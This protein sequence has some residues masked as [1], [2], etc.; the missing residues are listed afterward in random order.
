MKV[1]LVSIFLIALLFGTSSAYGARVVASG[2]IESKTIT[3]AISAL[4]FANPISV[5]M[6]LGTIFTLTVTGDTTLNATNGRNGQWIFFQF[7][8]D[9]AGPHT[10][11]FGTNFDSLGTLTTVAS[12]I[13]HTLFMYDGS[14]WHEESRSPVDGVALDLPSL[15]DGAANDVTVTDDGDGT[16]TISTITLGDIVTAGT[17]LSG[18]A[19]DVLPGADADTTI[20]LTAAK[21]IVAG[22]GLT[23]GE[24]NVL[25]G[26]DAD[27]TI[28]VGG[29]DG[30]I[31]NADEIEV[32]GLVASDG[33][34][35]DALTTDADGKATAGYGLAGDIY[36][37]GAFGYD[38]REY[39]AL[40]D[41]STDDSTA[42]TNAIAAAA[43][44]RVI[45]PEAGTS[46]RLSS[47]VTVPAGVTLGI[48]QGGLILIDTG[49]TLAINGTF[50]A[51]GYQIFDLTGTGIATLAAGSCQ[52]IL[53]QWWGA[54]GD[55]STDNA[56]P[57][58]E[59]LAQIPGI[60]RMY[61]PA[62]TYQTTTTIDNF[63]E[64]TYGL[65]S[66]GVVVEG[67]GMSDTIIKYTGT[68]GYAIELGANPSNSW[69][70]PHYATL[71]NMK[72][73][74]ASLTSEGGGVLLAAVSNVTLDHLSFTNIHNTNGIC[75]KS[76][77][78]NNT[79]SETFTD[80]TNNDFTTTGAGATEQY[81][82]KFTADRTAKLKSI[83]VPLGKTGAPAGTIL[84]YIY[85]DD[86]GAPSE[87]NA[88]IDGA[89]DAV[90][91]TAL[92]ADAG[93][94]D[95]TLTWT[96]RA[97]MPDI[98]NTNDYWVVLK[99]VGYTYADA[100]TEV[101]LRVESAGG[102]ADEFAAFDTGGAGWGTSADGVDN[103]V[104]YRSGLNLKN[105][106]SYVHA[107]GA[108]DAAV[109]IDN[110]D[111]GQLV[112]TNSD[113]YTEV[114]LTSDGSG[115]LE[116]KGMIIQANT[117]PA[118]ALQGSGLS[119][120]TN[121]YLEGGGVG[122][123]TTVSGG[124]HFWSQSSL[125]VYMEWTAGTDIEFE[126]CRGPL[127]TTADATVQ[128]PRYNYK[129]YDTNSQWLTNNTGTLTVDVD[130]LNGQ[131]TV[132]DAD[133][134]TAN[135]EFDGDVSKQ[136]TYLPK[137]TYK[138]SAYVKSPTP[139]TDGFWLR[140]RNFPDAVDLALETFTCTT[141][142]EEYS[143]FFKIDDD[144]VRDRFQISIQRL[145][146]QNDDLSVSHWTIE[147]M[148]PDLP[149]Q[150]NLQAYNSEES[151]AAGARVS[152]IEFRGKQSGGEE[153]L[154]ASIIARHV[155]SA[156]DEKGGLAFGVNDGDDGFALTTKLW[157]DSDFDIGLGDLSETIEDTSQVQILMEATKN[158]LIDGSTNPRN[159]TLGVIRFEHTPA[160]PD[161]RAI[162]LD[163]EANGMGDTH[164]IFLA[165][166]A[167][168]IAS[169]E[170]MMG[171]EV[172]LDRSN[173]TGGVM[174]GLRVSVGGAGSAAVH[175]L[176]A[177]PGVEV[178]HQEVGT[179]GAI[180][181]GWDENG[182]FTDV[183]AAFNS[184]VTDVT[185][186]SANGDMVH[187]GDAADFN[188]IEV[189]L[190]T[191]ASGAGVVPT[192]EYSI[193]GPAWT[194]FIPA[195]D[196][197]N[198]FRSSGT[199]AWDESTFTAWVATT[200]NGVNKKYIR[201]TRT[202]VG[203]G[204]SPIEDTI[205]IAVTIEYEWDEDG[206]LSV[207]SI[208][209]PT[210]ATPIEFS[211]DGTLVGDSDTAIP[212]EK[213]VKTYVDGAVPSASFS[214]YDAIVAAAGGDY[215]SVVTACATE[216]AGARIFVKRGT[217]NET[218]NIVMKDGQQLIGQ[219]PEDTIIDFGGNSAILTNDGAGTNRLVQGLTI[220][221]PLGSILVNLD[222]AYDRV[223]N[224]R[225]ISLGSTGT[226]LNVVGPHAVVSR[227]YIEGFTTSNQQGA[228]SGLGHD[229]LMI[230][231]TIENCYRGIRVNGD[232]CSIIGNSLLANTQAAIYVANDYTLISQNVMT[233][234]GDI[235]QSVGRYNVFDG[236]MMDDVGISFTADGDY[237]VVTNN[238]FANGA[239]F[240]NINGEYV[241]I[242]NNLFNGGLG[243][244]QQGDFATMSANIFQGTAFIDLHA[245]AADC[246]ITGNNLVDSSVATN[247]RITDAGDRNIALNNSGVPVVSE[248]QFVEMQNQSGGALAVGDVVT[249]NVAATG[250]EVTTTTTQGDDWVYGICAEAIGNTAWG[251]IQILGKTVALK[252]DGTAD[253][254]VGDLLGT[255]TTAKIAMQAAA[256][257]M[258]FAIA[259][260]AY[261]TDDSSGVIDALLISPR[262]Y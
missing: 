111:A 200:I 222:G 84:A 112:I 148:G 212:T 92:S 248:K 186:F 177:D 259:L 82:F 237:S 40:G 223:D 218:V 114:G 135:I 5:D 55:D 238:L 159:M 221:N 171:L 83:T 226:G 74:A 243:I 28:A 239:E 134:E 166:H 98:V 163:I 242:S 105:F 27:T 255:F 247:L 137:G 36:H 62:G 208:T 215:T 188:A 190:D 133:F 32:S 106:I 169:G 71:K 129:L 250:Y 197:T 10:I 205:Q 109:G 233:G 104:T 241:T 45:V 100:V 149:F 150:K 115:F 118:I 29:G 201:I 179:F 43:G 187:I 253:I 175:A 130:A 80:D 52:Y 119:Y 22:G 193:A 88:Q 210:G 260:E 30:V 225:I 217:Y 199:I 26:A 142:Y 257:D 194:A 17:G 144:D 60:G 49:I 57:F 21:D 11:T 207:A 99:T 72:I 13:H 152:R 41:G 56:T 34:P 203:L 113:F 16:I 70:S 254:A 64:G 7:T 162:H 25:P 231:N 90:T 18:G 164:G 191:P 42:F 245:D 3:G 165:L 68:S 174:E 211:T 4:S 117:G 124:R 181:Q 143:V 48:Q 97:D 153:S 167:D 136:Y 158:I 76:R 110:E 35:N 39:G 24:D 91:N 154:L 236:N 126:R 176:H 96:L 58:S 122:N 196:G 14:N 120:M 46:Y 220:Q 198:G 160:I 161:T 246:N 182:G 157:I 214:T 178:I 224:C 53:P 183:T 258:A 141:S 15:I 73:E 170:D 230:G 244:R 172:S 184:T 206:A 173:S 147:Y 86:G 89:S 9:G 213:A 185:I 81:A 132:F 204:T 103:V 262:K 12:D 8:D 78:Q 93:G 189:N 155:G 51:G 168:D 23:G 209:L 1:R 50:E 234:T 31:V 180:E 85:S 69:K 123:P 79:I 63:P 47:N 151:D 202:Q 235:V 251:R 252:V 59:A 19:N 227:N 116:M 75:I 256:G 61:I 249:I 240:D 6:D 108:S 44:G 192:F 145:A 66:N 54:L 125:G 37:D 140:V 87:P 38:V 102:D 33:N 101:R 219:N 228:Y 232:R 65:I 121:S 67:A 2:D 156:D 20:T 146:P 216:L 195:S 94:A 138:W 107:A 261:A 128:E 139:G 127:W 77:A 131:S 95:Q 229:N